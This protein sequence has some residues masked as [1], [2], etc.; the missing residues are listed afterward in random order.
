MTIDL[1][2]MSLILLDFPGVASEWTSPLMMKMSLTNAADQPR[3]DQIHQTRCWWHIRPS[4]P[5]T[6]RD[7]VRVQ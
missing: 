2:T 7:P 5:R 1:Q 3:P 6:G 4:Q